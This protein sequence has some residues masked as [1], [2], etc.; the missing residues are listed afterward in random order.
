MGN[1]YGVP[2]WY[3]GTAMEHYGC[4]TCRK[5]NTRGERHADVVEFLSQHLVMPG[6]S[7][8]KLSTKAAKELIQVLKILGPTN[9][10]TIIERQLNF[11]NRLETLFN[12]MQPEK[13]QTKV[14]HREV[15]TIAPTRVTITVSPPRVPAT[16]AP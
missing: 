10:F 13:T 2:G 12:I 1:I 3:I 8:T 6:L 16:V 15:P 7:T 4:Y 5:P 9:P 14:L 11:I